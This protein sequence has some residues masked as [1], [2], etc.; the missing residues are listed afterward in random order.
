MKNILFRG[1]DKFTGTW[2]Y[3]DLV[4]NKK[5]TQT[6]LEDRVMVGGFEVIE[7]T[8]GQYIGL[9]DIM[10]DK[11]FEGDIIRSHNT[12]IKHLIV[13]CNDAASFMAYP[14]FA[15]TRSD[16][17]NIAVFWIKYGGK[18]VIGNIYDNPRMV[19]RIPNV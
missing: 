15:G 14:D 8:V 6:G 7:E 5:V 16:F 3:G 4:H 19:K 11:I 13:F 18:E 2:R 1:K 10:G 12:N 17:C 9:L